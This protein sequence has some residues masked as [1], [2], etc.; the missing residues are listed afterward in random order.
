ML[1]RD[2]KNFSLENVTALYERMCRLDTEGRRKVLGPKE[3]GRADIIVAGLAIARSFLKVSGVKELKYSARGL[4]DG[5]LVEEAVKAGL[6]PLELGDA[7]SLRRAKI[8]QLGDLYRFDKAHAGQVAKFACKLFDELQPIHKY[9]DEE[10]D[11]LEAAAL[12]HDIGHH[13][14]YTKHHKHTYYLIKNSELAG[15][16]EMEVNIIANVARYHRKAHPSDHHIPYRELPKDRR[17]QVQMLAALL[18][19]ADACDRR[20][21]QAISD[22]KVKLTDEMIT[23]RLIASDSAEVERWL[24]D[25]RAA[26]LFESVYRRKVTVEVKPK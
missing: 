19:I 17:R 4:R 8:I 25:E 2:N 7:R 12:L 24:V 22:L 20:H 11:L 13:I 15:F 9:G 21:I 23:L 16:D 1:K 18:R 5:L 6:R 14:S 26:D 10:R 3:A